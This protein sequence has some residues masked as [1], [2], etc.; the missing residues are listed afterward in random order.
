[1]VV[2]VA[3]AINVTVEIRL[4]STFAFCKACLKPFPAIA[5][6]IGEL[7]ATFIN[8][9][10]PLFTL[11][12][13]L[14]VTFYG[15]SMHESLLTSRHLLLFRFTHLHFYSYDLAQLA[16]KQNINGKQ[17]AVTFIKKRETDFY[18]MSLMVTYVKPIDFRTYHQSIMRR[19]HDDNPQS[20]M[21]EA[22]SQLHRHELSRWDDSQLTPHTDKCPSRG[23][24]RITS[25]IKKLPPAHPNQ[26]RFPPITTRSFLMFSSA[27]IHRINALV[28]TAS[29]TIGHFSGFIQFPKT[30]ASYQEKS[31]DTSGNRGNG[32]KFACLFTPNPDTLGQLLKLVR[33][34]RGLLSDVL[35]VIVS[36]KHFRMGPF[37]IFYFPTTFHST[38][39]PRLSGRKMRRT[40]LIQLKN[41]LILANEILKLV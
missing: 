35:R 7:T 8:N 33:E 25:H 39:S 30:I 19:L 10:V 11:M 9:K 41:T 32:T 2:F 18:R 6:D 17:I 24:S 38:M 14:N 34:S 29:V 23:D 15:A 1:M 20:G 3:V 13:Y 26:I 22:R 16:I 27:F 4:L 12:L 31:G 5:A 40:S 37:Y 36:P 28:V 21:N